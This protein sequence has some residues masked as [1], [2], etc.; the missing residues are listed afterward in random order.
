V[1]L[2]KRKRIIGVTL[3]VIILPSLTLYVTAVA[4][5]WYW[6]PGNP[7]PPPTFI[8]VPMMIPPAISNATF[9]WPDLYLGISLQATGPIAEG[10]E[11]TFAGA[12]WIGSHDYYL[13]FY[14]AEV[15][16]Q[17]SI[18][19]RF[20]NSPAVWEVT[21]WPAVITLQR[22]MNNQSNPNLWASANNTE[23]YFPTAGDYSPTVLI[24]FKQS[25][26]I[27]YTYD[28]I[29]I[30]VASTSDIENAKFTRVNTALSYVLVFFAG[31]ESVSII[32]DFSEDE[33]KDE[34]KDRIRHKE[35]VHFE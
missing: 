32:R 6:F 24:S 17:E 12:G 4:K 23:I 16:F 2:L 5:D 27:E 28:D 18:P 25:K 31:I 7:A 15:F 34:R 33:A 19:W 22:D 8:V 1:G 21:E 3:F 14:G 11:V 20:K 26:P 13:R 9:P 10:T 30:H 35:A 29:K